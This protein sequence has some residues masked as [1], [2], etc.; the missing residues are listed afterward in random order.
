MMSLF[1]LLFVIA[2]C[3]LAFALQATDESHDHEVAAYLKLE[4]VVD[5]SQEDAHQ[6]IS[7]ANWAEAPRLELL[8]HDDYYEPDELVLE[9]GKPYVLVIKNV[10]FKRHDIS[11][12]HFFS[13]IVVKSLRYKG[14]VV[15]AYHLESVSLAGDDVAEVEIVT[16]FEGEFPFICT[17]QDH[18]HEG[19]EGLLTVVSKSSAEKAVTEEVHK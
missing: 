13:N 17:V 7:A 6:I 8:L 11:S 16:A 2:L 1:R 3:P 14:L 10:G 9:A 12:E 18:L 19:M 4:N 5:L 15:S